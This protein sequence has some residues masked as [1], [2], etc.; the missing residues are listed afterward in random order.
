MKEKLVKLLLESIDLNGLAAG[1]IDEILEE[2]LKKVVADS[3]NTMDDMLMAAIYP[4]LEKELKE[5][6]K[7]LV[8]GL[9][10]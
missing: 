7:E 2:A 3:S 8:D 9:N 5:K 4:V 6:I 10:S 1:L